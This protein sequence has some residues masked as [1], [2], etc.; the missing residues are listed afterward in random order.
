MLI[1]IQTQNFKLTDSIHDYAERRL[2]FSLS[3]C[4]DR[5]QRVEMRLTDTNI[6]R[7]GSDKRCL[8]RIIA[9]DLPDIVIEDI[10]KDIHIAINRATDRAGRTVIRKINRQQSMLMQGLPTKTE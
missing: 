6:P 5:I 10:Q 9:P 2:R 7:G 3:Y 8:L 4:D 1:D